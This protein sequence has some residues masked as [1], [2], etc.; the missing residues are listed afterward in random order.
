MHLF[1]LQTRH[2]ILH[3]RTNCGQLPQ[4]QGKLGSV[5]ETKRDKNVFENANNHQNLE[6]N[7]QTLLNRPTFGKGNKHDSLN[8]EI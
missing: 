5:R 2:S 3:L 7:C 1:D 8:A 6:N 4:P